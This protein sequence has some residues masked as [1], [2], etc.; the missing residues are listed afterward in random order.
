[1]GDRLP[2]M[3]TEWATERAAKAGLPEGRLAETFRLVNTSNNP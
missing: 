1:M 3:L 2:K